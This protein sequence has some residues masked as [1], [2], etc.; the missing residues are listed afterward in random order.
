MKES[1]KKA[2]VL[3]PKA[4][5]SSK[6]PSI[7]PVYIRMELLNFGREVLSLASSVSHQDLVFKE[8]QIPLFESHS[9][10]IQG[11]VFMY[12]LDSTEEGRRV[13]WGSTRVRQ[14][15]FTKYMVSKEGRV[16]YVLLEVGVR[17]CL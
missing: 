12:L 11:R 5:Q 17:G 14:G 3:R 6:S 13:V 16:E 2:A 10:Y 7:C 1:K 15:R 9:I 4:R 8:E